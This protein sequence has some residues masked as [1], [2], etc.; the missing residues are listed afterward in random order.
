ML[1]YLFIFALLIALSAEDI[2]RREAQHKKTRFAFAFLAITLL[3]GLRAPSVGTDTKEYIRFFMDTNTPYYRDTEFGFVQYCK[4]LGEVSKSST[5]FLFISGILSMAGIGRIVYKRSNHPALSLLMF[6]CS[7]DLMLLY[8]SGIRQSIAI[9][10]CML[11]IDSL[12]D[13]KK[14]W[15]RAAL[16][17]LTAISFHSSAAIIILAIIPILWKTLTKPAM[18]LSLGLGFF[19]GITGLIDESKFI[20]PFVDLLGSH[21]DVAAERYEGYAT[22][23]D[24]LKKKST[25]EY[26]SLTLV[27]NIITLL[28]IINTP[29]RYY[30]TTW[31]W[32]GVTLT[33]LFAGFPM[34]WRMS[35][36]FTIFQVILAPDLLKNHPR[37]RLAFIITL[38]AYMARKEW[39]S[40]TITATMKVGNIVLPYS[41]SI[42]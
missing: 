21:I 3:I 20:A 8:L 17:W 5:L 32:I 36:Y 24:W 16:F 25:A 6:Y 1:T 19:I 9:S 27:L 38:I 33:N 7:Y 35:I 30:E 2:L 34:I 23:S 41:T 31:L 10:F 13:E 37:L 18:L 40:I 4:W 26:L 12:M 42:F 14:H 22:D 15:V 11:A 39:Y 29:H 28:A